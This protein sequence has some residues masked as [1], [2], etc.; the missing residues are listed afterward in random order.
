LV[1]KQPV[2]VLYDG[3]CGICSWSRD[4]AASRD[5]SGLLR[6]I[7]FQ[8]ADLD[9]LSPGLTSEMASRMAWVVKADGTRFGGARAVFEVLSRLNGAWALIGWLGANPI[10][11]AIFTPPYRLMAVQRHRISALLGMNAC[12]L[13]EH[14]LPDPAA[15]A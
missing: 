9:A 7:P 11:S 3:D 1:S 13:P 15:R 4:F 12:K 14:K 6:L 2:T 10:I 8:S 5:S